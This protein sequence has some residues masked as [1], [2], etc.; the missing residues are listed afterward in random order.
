ML[1]EGQWIEDD[2]KLRN[3]PKGAF[4]RPDSVFRS[5]ITADGSSGFPAQPGRYH[6]WVSFS[7]PWAHRTLIVRRMK[8]LDDVISITASGASRAQGWSFTQGIDALQP[9]NGVLQLHQVYAA[10]SPTYT[11]RVTVPAL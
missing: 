7:C 1:L 2:A 3:D 8:K 4:V 10:A 11:G 5:R 6:L 9:R